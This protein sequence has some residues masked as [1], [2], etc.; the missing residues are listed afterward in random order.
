M[1]ICVC[2][3]V[4]QSLLNS[5]LD[6]LLVYFGQLWK[7]GEI[8]NEFEVFGT[9][10]TNKTSVGW[11]K[12]NKLE[13][14]EGRIVSKSQSNFALRENVLFISSFQIIEPRFEFS[15]CWAIGELLLK[16]A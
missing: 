1:F 16:Y 4:F 8:D 10:K 3:Q 9:V 7:G 11:K 14:I 5:F 12:G 15:S 13:N 2:F 6:I